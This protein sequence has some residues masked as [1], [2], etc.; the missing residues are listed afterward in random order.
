MGLADDK[1]VA[2]TDVNQGVWQSLKNGT[3]FAS[4][5]MLGMGIIAVLTK[6]PIFNTA[7]IG[8]NF[9]LVSGFPGCIQHF[10]VRLI[11]WYNNYIPWNYARFLDYATERIFLQKVGGGYIFIHRMLME[12][13]A[14]MQPEK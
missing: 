12:H 8:L 6:L 13:F 5:G 10:I 4:I 11:L 14:Q 3:V 7:M 1:I 2:T 9:G